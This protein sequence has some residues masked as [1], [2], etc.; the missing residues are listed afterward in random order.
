MQVGGMQLRVEAGRADAVGR[1]RAYLPRD[2][3][4]PRA[5]RVE[6]QPFVI[7]LDALAPGAADDHHSA[8][9]CIPE[10]LG[11]RRQ[12]LRLDDDALGPRPCLE[13]PP[14]QVFVERHAR[15]A[16]P[17]RCR[18]ASVLLDGGAK[19]GSGTVDAG[20]RVPQGAVR[21]LALKRFF[22]ENVPLVVD[23]VVADGESHTAGLAAFADDRH[24]EASFGRKPIRFRVSSFAKPQTLS[25]RTAAR[26]SPHILAASH[27][28]SRKL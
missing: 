26:M 16:Y 1:E 22:G 27:R 2:P 7:E 24:W 9:P 18:S 6:M 10:E 20:R 5:D 4:L 25:E 15:A 11:E 17:G 19:R 3:L 21:N 8:G 23:A 14:Y 13:S 12:P 28:W